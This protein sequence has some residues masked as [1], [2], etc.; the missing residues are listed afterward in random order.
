MRGSRL[1]L[2]LAIGGA[3][4]AGAVWLWRNQGDLGMRRPI[5]EWTFTHMRRIMPVAEVRAEPGAPLPA[6]PALELSEV[7]A[8]DDP[9]RSLAALPERNHVTGLVIL[10]RGRIV[11]ESYPGRFA[12]RSARFQLFSLTKSVTS[13]LVGIAHA[14][15][16]IPD[17]DGTVEAYLPELAGS[18]FAPV[19]IRQ[20]LDMTSGVGGAED[21]TDPDA[22]IHRYE[23]AVMNGGSVFEVIR[24]APRLAAP[25]ARFN[26]STIDTHVLGWV[27]EAAVG[28]PLAEILGEKLWRPIGAESDAFYFLS[29]ADPRSALG[30]GSLNATLR[31]LAR[32]GLLVARGGSWEGRQVVPREWIEACRDGGR[33]GLGVGEL[34]PEFY[35]AHYGYSRLWWR[36]GG[37]HR[38]ITGLGVHGQFLVVD[39]DADVVIA[40]TGAWDDADDDVRDA[41]MIAA[42]RAIISHL[43]SLPR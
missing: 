8:A 33:P 4:G 23:R 24:T 7:R 6:G 40:A 42:A 2:P 39:L 9:T 10:H 17:L 18:A 3:I 38:A 22:I 34:D 43:G 11:H 12:S 21:W 41:E 14:E 15:G 32:V 31:D 35:P 1:I 25:G 19:T 26:Y 30:G 13:L 16:D 5:N 20:L 28:E 29:R 27:L 37:E 36:L